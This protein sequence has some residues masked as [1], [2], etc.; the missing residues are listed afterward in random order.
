MKQNSQL[1]NQERCKIDLEEEIQSF[2]SMKDKLI[3]RSGVVGDVTDT[4]EWEAYIKANQDKT[5]MF[6]SR[7]QFLKYY[8]K[9]AQ[10]HLNAQ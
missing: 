5:E 1:Q 3:R 2:K 10:E 9:S 4:P 8:G 7:E 6:D